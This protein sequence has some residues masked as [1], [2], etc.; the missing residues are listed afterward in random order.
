MKVNGIF[1]VPF[2]GASNNSSSPRRAG[3]RQ[4]PHSFSP[5]RGW[6]RSKQQD[7][8]LLLTVALCCSQAEAMCRAPGAK[9]KAKHD[10]KNNNLSCVE[11]LSQDNNALLFAWG[12]RSRSGPSCLFFLCSN[13]GIDLLVK[14]ICRKCTC[15]GHRKSGKCRYFV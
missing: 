11:L 14:N 13:L 10:A 3:A 15:K 2:W 7:G 9:E 4:H 6:E 12:A 8:P 5:F 1:P